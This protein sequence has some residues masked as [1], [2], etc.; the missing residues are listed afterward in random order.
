MKK[1][2]DIIS[3]KRAKM[4]D[5]LPTTIKN[6]SSV[7]YYEY[8]DTFNKFTCKTLSK[9]I[10]IAL[11]ERK[12]SLA[13]LCRHLQEDGY[14]YNYASLCNAFNGKNKFISNFNYFAFLYYYLDL[15]FPSLE[16]LNSFD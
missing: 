8:R 9:P 15:P 3:P 14:N 13:S 2:A 6:R 7:D 12:M 4:R 1:S 5:K 16:Y 10:L 11:Q